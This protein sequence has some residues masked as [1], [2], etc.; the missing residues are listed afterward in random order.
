MMWF[1]REELTTLFNDTKNYVATDANA[2]V[3]VYNDRIIID[4]IL[5]SSLNTSQLSFVIYLVLRE[6]LQI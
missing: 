1:L 6:S 3:I 4:D 5:P 2:T